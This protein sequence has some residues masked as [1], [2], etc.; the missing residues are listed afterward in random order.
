MIYIRW[1]RGGK[2]RKSKL[3]FKNCTVKSESI[4]LQEAT[5]I[6]RQSKQ[7]K[8]KQIFCGRGQVKTV[9]EELALESASIEK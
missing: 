9:A 4:A 2:E 5:E 6:T 3:N 7:I 8:T 1:N